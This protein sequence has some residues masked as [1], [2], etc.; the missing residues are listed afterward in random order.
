MDTLLAGYAAGTLSRPLHV[1]VAAHLTLAPRSRNYVDALEVLKGDALEAAAPVPV[2]DREAKLSAIFDE[3]PDDMPADAASR[4]PADDLLP[5]PLRAFVGRP[6]HAIPWKTMLP[7]IKEHAIGSNERGMAHLIAVKP[8]GRIPVHTHEGTEV[9]LVL[10]GSFSDAS[11]VYRRGDICFA[12]E[13][14]DHHP[15]ADEVEGCV[16]FIVSDAPFRLTG[17]F[18]RIVEWLFR[19]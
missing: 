12:D 9:T 10:R 8:G 6:G 2:R 19:R 18:G 11:G 14:V 16:C 5:A 1:L 4:E 15:V 13:T 7:G 3:R 17:R